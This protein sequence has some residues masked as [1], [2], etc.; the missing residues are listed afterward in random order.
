MLGGGTSRAYLR[1]GWS[2][3]QH[4]PNAL[5]YPRRSFI[6][7]LMKIRIGILGMPNVGKSSLFNALAQKSI[8]QAANFPFC[9]IEPNV[10][11]VALP[12]NRLQSLGTLANSLRTVHATLDWLDVAGLARGASRGEGLGNKFLGELRECDA[13]AHVVR[14]FDSVHV[15]HVDG[16]VDPVCDAET[17]NLELLLADLEHVE[18]R[19]Q[20]A[21]GTEKRILETVVACLR[22]GKPAR[23]AGLSESEKFAVKSMGLLTMKPVLYCFNVDEVDFTYGREE[24]VSRCKKVLSSL[25]YCD[26]TTDKF[27]L[28]SAKIE[29]DICELDESQQIAYFDSLGFDIEDGESTGSFFSHNALPRAIAEMLGLSIVYTGP[30][31]PQVCSR[32]GGMAAFI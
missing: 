2:T 10:A 15:V 7:V 5:S 20:R 18:R 8:A 3:L 27:A 14:D 6:P 22:E 16:I 31:V 12:D 11:T 4:Q 17:I 9:T 25:A 1:R 28:V 24:A 26:S 30:G 23:A 13:L 21:K 29:S 19:F 32:G